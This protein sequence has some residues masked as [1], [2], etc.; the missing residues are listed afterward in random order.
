M[1]EWCTHLENILKCMAP[2]NECYKIEEMKKL[3]ASILEHVVMELEKRHKNLGELR[4]CPIYMELVGADWINCIPGWM[5]LS[6]FGVAVIGLIVLT[7]PKHGQG[8]KW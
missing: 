3:N 8:S 4:D 7:L 5:I 1:D 2:Y 6:I